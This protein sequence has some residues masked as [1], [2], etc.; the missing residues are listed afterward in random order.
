MD[1]WS[2]GLFGLMTVG[3]IQCLALC[4]E[5]I[6]WY[7]PSTPRG[8]LCCLT[9]VV[10]SANARPCHAHELVANAAGSLLE[11]LLGPGIEVT[12]QVRQPLPGALLT[13]ADSLAERRQKL[14]ALAARHGWERFARRSAMAPVHVELNYIVDAGGQRVGHHVYSAFV[15]YAKLEQLRDQQ[16]MEGLFGSAGADQE[17]VGFAPEAVSTELLQ[18][19][20]IQIADE[21][22]ERYATF[23]APLMNRVELRGT[24]RVEK[25]ESAGFVL[26]AWQLDPRFTFA[27][28][29]T[30]TDELQSLANRAFKV[31]RDE[32][33]QKTQSAPT[34]Y[35]GCGGYVS[36]QETGLETD[37]LLIETRLVLHEPPDWFSGSNFL[38]SKFP[39]VLQESAQ[40]FRRKLELARTRQ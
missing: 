12:A 8:M 29:A 18:Q 2:R 15:A 35:S 11:L 24:A 10:L 25:I 23:F 30:P 33:G 4:R 16:L 14:N 28:D 27:A 3:L 34:P 36:V 7:A 39:A 9:I 21:S 6:S 5:V 40:T 13:P 31:Q 38:R 32:L 17:Q 22:M 1:R 37:Q 20:G 19:L 26:M